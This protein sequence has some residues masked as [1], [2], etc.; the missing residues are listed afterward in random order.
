LLAPTGVDWKA[1]ALLTLPP[2]AVAL[3]WRKDRKLVL[4]GACAIAFLLG[5]IR[6]QV[7]LPDLD[8]P[9]FV[10]HFND[11]GWATVEGA[12]DD[13]PS[14]RDTWT[15]LTLRA[16]NVEFGGQIHQVRGSVLVR[17][18]RFPEYSYGDALRVSGWLQTPPV[19]EGFSYREYLARKGIYSFINRP[20]IE[21]IASGMGDPLRKAIYATKDRAHELL[22]RLVPDP[23]AALLQGILLGIRGGIP[24]DL[25][26]DFNATGTS[27]IIVISGANMMVIAALFSLSF[28]RLMGKR[29]AYWLTIVGLILYSLLV[30]ADPVVLRAGVMAGLFATALYLGRQS[31]AYVSLVGSV[32]FLTMINP[33]TLW[34]VGFQLSF[35]AT[36]GL[37][38]FTPLLKR[39]LEQRV[40]RFLPQRL[41]QGL[42]PYLSDYVIVTLAAMILVIPLVVHHFGRLSLV[43]PL[44]NALILPVQ[45]TIM[46]GGG[47]ATLIG[48]IPGLEPLARLV[49]WI[50]WLC[51]A[52]TTS[53]VRLMA[54]LPSASVQIGQGSWRWLIAYYALTFA[55]VWAVHQR[56]ATGDRVVTLARSQASSKAVLGLLSAAMILAGLAVVQLPDGRLHVAILDVGQ[57]DAILVTTPQGQQILIDGGPSPA[58]LTSALGEQMPFW[59][60]SIDLLVITHSD[61]D[62]VTGLAEV[63]T[64]YKV[65]GWLESG[66]PDDDAIFA[67]CQDLLK[68]AGVPRYS[69][70]AGARLDLEPG[71]AIEIIHPPKE[72]MTG[73]TSDSNNNSVVLRLV[74]GQ[75]SFL[76]TGDLGAEGEQLL[77]RS[78]QA[79]S[80]DVLKVGHHGSGGSS[81]PE[82]LSAVSP[83]FAVISVAAENRFGHPDQAVVVRLAQRGTTILRTDEQGTTEFITD[84]YGLWVEPEE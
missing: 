82:F 12:V 11:Q 54:A 40:L 41:A 61:E 2:L 5:A 35:A 51:L 6:Y 69:A 3:L 22:G 36:L 83:R 43:A 8:D 80:A 73:T 63:L 20:Q 68:V 33:L 38:L 7:Q 24:P 42:M 10:A 26:D 44:A 70:R 81:T 77:L 16:Q 78:G 60:R 72:L 32:V 53:V 58:A 31:T 29:R 65:G 45:P 15:N 19:L 47:A 50:P 57:G 66:R 55:F 75:A 14:V 37:I 9:E 39:P 34:D 18:P 17:A 76:L 21:L 49:A 4:S 46:V 62:H 48:M 71:L 56:Q 84:G 28:G 23:E 67:E 79:L 52:Y 64:R 25:Y 13:Y 59:D 27:H 1:L 74:W 30:G